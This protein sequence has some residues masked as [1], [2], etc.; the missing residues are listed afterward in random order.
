MA[1]PCG[2]KASAMKSV[3]VTTKPMKDVMM[4]LMENTTMPADS[5]G[6]PLTRRTSRGSGLPS[7]GVLLVQASSTPFQMRNM[8]SGTALPKMIVGVILRR[9]PSS[10]AQIVGTTL[11]NESPCSIVGMQSIERCQSEVTNS[12][13]ASACGTVRAKRPTKEMITT[14]VVRLFACSTRSVPFESIMNPPRPR[15]KATQGLIHIDARPGS[16]VPRISP[17]RAMNAVM[18]A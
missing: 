2:L 17:P 11:W 9:S 18:V 1:A 4:A 13:L 15:A 16:R 14:A 5:T 6:P 7:S 10:C 3:M 8:M 12:W